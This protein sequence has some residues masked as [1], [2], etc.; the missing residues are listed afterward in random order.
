MSFKKNIKCRQHRGVVIA[1]IE[2]EPDGG[3][4]LTYWMRTVTPDGRILVE[5]QAARPGDDE[6]LVLPRG[7]APRP[8]DEVRLRL[9]DERIGRGAIPYIVTWCLRCNGEIEIPI[10]WLLNEANQSGTAVCPYGVLA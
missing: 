4:V 2:R 3:K 10:D 6:P 8:G 7:G 1:V 5:G 9:D